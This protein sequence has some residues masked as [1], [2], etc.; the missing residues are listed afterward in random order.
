MA[1]VLL[2][3]SPQGFLSEKCAALEAAGLVLG[4]AQCIPS[5]IEQMLKERPDLVL[6]A[7]R[8]AGLDAIDLL[9]LS[10]SEP[11]LAEIPFFVC[12]ISNRQS[13]KYLE[14]GEDFLAYP[15]SDQELVVR[16][17]SALKRARRSGVTGDFS[18][19]GIIDLLQLLSAARRD[20]SLEVHLSDRVGELLFRGGQ[21]FHANCGE[22]QGEDAFLALMR[23]AQRGGKFL[24]SAEPPRLAAQNV[25]KRTEHILLGL[26]NLLDEEV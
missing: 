8:G 15:I 4:R 21:V 1:R 6:V 24:F 23:A 9:E 5:A 17:R 25:L 7:E 20:G 14:L 19:L 3:D 11:T 26:A 22:L 13:L 10:L 2:V 18:H 12:G 16:L